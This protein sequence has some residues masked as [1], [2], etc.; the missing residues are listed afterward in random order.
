[1]VSIKKS[2]LLLLVGCTMICV[3]IFNV[4]MVGRHISSI[5]YMNEDE[6][7]SFTVTWMGDD[8]GGS[9][10]TAKRSRIS[11]GRSVSNLRSVASLEKAKQAAKRLRDNDQSRMKKAG[12]VDSGKVGV[13][14]DD[15]KKTEVK[16]N[17]NKKDDKND[18]AKEKFEKK[19]DKKDV[20]KANSE[21]KDI[22]KKNKVKKN[23]TKKD[24]S[25]EKKVIKKIDLPEIRVEQPVSLQNKVNENPVENESKKEKVKKNS[26]KKDANK[27]KEVIKNIELSKIRVEQPVSVEKK[28]EE[29]SNKNENLDKKDQNK[30]E[31]VKKIDL[32]QIRVE[33][34][35]DHK[36]T[37]TE[38]DSS[39]STTFVRHNNVVIAT[40]IHGDHQWPLLVQSMCLLHYA[41]N[42]KVLYDVA[43]FSTEPIP[44]EDI[45]SLQSMISPAKLHLVVDN[46]G[47]QTEI[48]YLSR[49][50]HEGFL[51]MCNVTD[52]TNIT[53]WSECS[54]N[55][56][57]YNWQA[58]FRGFHLW[59][60]PSM[61][62]YKTMMWLDTDG[63]ATK[64]W[65][66]DPIDYFIKNDG[67]VMFDNFPHAHSK[68]TMQK[69]LTG[70]GAS[71]CG[72]K[73]SEEGH[74]VSELNYDGNCQERGIPNIHG[75]LHITNLDFYR[76][77]RVQMGLFDLLGDCF[78][79]REPDDQLAVTAPAA[80]LAPERSWEMRSKGFHLNVFHNYK[81]DGK[82]QAKPA[83]FLKYWDA[84]GKH[85]HPAAAE[86]C[87]VTEAG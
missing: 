3:V 12:T 80:I 55:R 6:S 22:K 40:K 41:Y 39:N 49:E 34:P 50:K 82:D 58:E 38:L 19:D 17:S 66:E 15:R 29:N 61:N 13:R 57:A 65:K 10:V 16:E 2:V 70:F 32:P 30:E 5:K 64:P 74:L 72:L 14:K 77:R 85:T 42:H 4:I 62:D 9:R 54:G 35:V 1:M 84:I 47:L 75:F 37:T 11:P 21:K 44:Q 69:R 79:C 18:E 76:S 59:T 8:N 83:G 26:T 81:L 33:Q 36:K 78:L 45:D 51:K 23:P 28:V 86:V 46:R 20:V 7:F 56:L 67:V 24:E 60:H 27:E 43:V 87:K 73:L 63:F 52:T 68:Y 48:A 31:V 25:E 53:W 71:I